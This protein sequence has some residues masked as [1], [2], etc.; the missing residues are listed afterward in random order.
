MEP[1]N[2]RSNH[3]LWNG[4][5]IP[6][7][8]NAYHE[9]RPPLVSMS[10]E[11]SAQPVLTHRRLRLRTSLMIRTHLDRYVSGGEVD[12]SIATRRIG[13]VV[14]AARMVHDSDIG[15]IDHPHL[16]CKTKPLRS[17]LDDGMHESN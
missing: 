6:E 11:K 2:E 15:W 7:R 8:V 13:C 1:R 5:T 10:S 3:K 4:M 16:L 14:W 17:V 12:S 9:S